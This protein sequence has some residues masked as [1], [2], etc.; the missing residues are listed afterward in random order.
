VV[1]WEDEKSS[2]WRI[3]EELWKEEEEEKLGAWEMGEKWEGGS[4]SMAS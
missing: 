2:S 4:S 3:S 1:V